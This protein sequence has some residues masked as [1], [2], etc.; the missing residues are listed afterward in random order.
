LSGS[1]SF[2]FFLLR[3]SPLSRAHLLITAEDRLQAGSRRR[4]PP[5]P[6]RAS[7]SHA[8]APNAA[9]TRTRTRTRTPTPTTRH[10]RARAPL[11]PLLEWLAVLR[12]GALAAEALVRSELSSSRKMAQAYS[13]RRDLTALLRRLVGVD[14][15]SSLQLQERPTPGTETERPQQQRVEQSALEGPC[16]AVPRRALGL[17]LAQPALRRCGVRVRSPRRAA[18]SLAG[19]ACAALAAADRTSH[20]DVTLCW[21]AVAVPR[22]KEHGHPSRASA[23]AFVVQGAEEVGHWWWCGCCPRCPGRGC[24]V[25]LPSS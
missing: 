7:P 23:T 1:F 10:G 18:A 3:L 5:S 22:R 17:P 4:Q 19:P 12:W 6:G 21:P 20:L 16:C 8:A 9:H 14:V 24:R 25:S 11:L 15:R 2:P 13:P